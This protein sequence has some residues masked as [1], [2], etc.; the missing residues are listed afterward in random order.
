[1]KMLSLS[2]SDGIG[3]K[4]FLLLLWC[5]SVGVVSELRQS[6]L[7]FRR[8]LEISLKFDTMLYLKNI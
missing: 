5:R 1:M 3:T 6:L 7:N 4:R 8:K 2:W